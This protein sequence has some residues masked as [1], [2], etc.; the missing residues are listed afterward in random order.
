[1]S[2]YC[3]DRNTKPILDAARHW[4]DHALLNGGSVFTDRRLWIPSS[5]AAL[6][7][8]FV[9]RPS[10][11]SEKFLTKFERQLEP[12]DAASKQLASEMIWLMYLC[13]SSLTPT[14]KRKTVQ[15]VWDWSGE[16][17]PADSQW[18]SEE[19]LAGI[20][21]A[22]A[23]F[24]Q[25]QW[26]ELVFL[27]TLVQYFHLLEGEEQ[28]RIA[29]DPWAFDE[30][31][32][33]VPD[34]EARQ[35]RHMLLYL[36]FPDD[37][38]RVFGQSDRRA[39]LRHFSHRDRKALNRMNAIEIDRELRDVRRR[40]ESERSTTDL[41]YYLPPLVDEWKEET[42]VDVAPEL[43]AAHV[44]Q[45]LQEIDQTGV[46]SDA[47]STTYDLLYNGKRYP[48]KYVLSL[49]VKH[50]KGRPLNRALFSGGEK[51][52]A[53][54]ILRDLGFEILSKNTNME[55]ISE[56]LNRFH[57][58]SKEG[59]QLGVQNYLKHYR[60][61]RIE[62]S[63]GKGNFAR[64]PW[65]AFLA[66]GQ[67]VSNGIYPVL[68]HF[69]KEQ[70]LLLCYG[71]SETTVPVSTWGDLKDS[72]SVRQWFQKR[73]SRDPDRYGDSFV[74]AAY[75]T[76]Q[77]LPVVEIQRLLDQMVDF[78][79]EVLDMSPGEALV[80]KAE[81]LPIRID[82]RKTAE[83][84]AQALH[85]SDVHFGDRHNTIAYS[86]IASLATKPLLILTG[87]SGSGKTQIAIRFGEWI[88]PGRLHVAAVRPDWTGA[89][90]L[91]GYEDG[92]KAPV[93]G[94]AAW[95]VP[96]SLEF[97]LKA[98]SDPQHPYLLLLDEMNLSHV[99]RYFADVLSG[100]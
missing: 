82:L 68:L 37:F 47:A 58:Q 18:M 8:H 61:L 10:V 56:L 31:L 60:E 63:F 29:H 52:T 81:K 87:L 38:E 48:P 51:S 44:L 74:C 36:L 39:I 40:L 54:R 75:D 50:A 98:A 62:V 33:Q 12:V 3:G 83:H 43:I 78:Y 88:G 66:A 32:T 97:M 9:Q 57:D 77:P 24:N 1:M 5:I 67:K 16:P 25:N 6:D 96:S 30:W 76:N 90:A 26:R 73:F 53:F 20:G 19:T 11:A 70:V 95:S 45:A 80:G 46:P 93:N 27:I 91:F 22:G 86:F 79:K 41:D 21:S 89:E 7:T 85:A 65:I 34:S 4:R 94:L 23:G 42:I 49:A 13:P 59:E 35:L 100:M 99:E 72:V 17:F 69:R 84:F 55:D 2:R 92:L 71:I 64:I 28:R 14:H 15:T